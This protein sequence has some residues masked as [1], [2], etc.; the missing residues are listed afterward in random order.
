MMTA[1]SKQT[2]SPACML[3]FTL[4][5]LPRVIVRPF[6]FHV[7]NQSL[8]LTAPFCC[9]IRYRLE[10]KKRSSPAPPPPAC[11]NVEDAARGSEVFVPTLNV[12]G[13]EGAM[14][15]RNIKGT[16]FSLDPGTVLG[17]FFSLAQ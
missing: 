10:R 13:G 4:G 15:Q 3:S 16:F 12:Y 8:R 17:T 11:F 7:W 14:D 1:L 9:S 5:T 2:Y 6:K